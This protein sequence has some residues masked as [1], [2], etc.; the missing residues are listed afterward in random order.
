[1]QLLMHAMIKVNDKLTSF[2]NSRYLTPVAWVPNELDIT[3]L[4]HR[5]DW[6][7]VSPKYQ[8][9]DTKKRKFGR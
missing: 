8:Q 6:C 9:V 4:L 5:P 7:V 1:M 3:Q 2:G